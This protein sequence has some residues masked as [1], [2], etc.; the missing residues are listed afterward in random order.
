MSRC[1]GLVAP[2]AALAVAVAPA[3]GQSLPSCEH[4][5]YR[6]NFRLNGAEQH[7]TLAE[8]GKTEPHAEVAHALQLLD[9]ARRAGGVDQATLWYLFAR[10]YVLNHD[11]VGA[12]SA[13]TKAEGATDA[14]C[15]AQIG[16]LRYNQW[17]PLFNS[18]LEQMN[19]GHT[20]S[21]LAMFRQANGIYRSRPDAYVFMA[22]LFEQENPPQDDSA[23]RYFR[24]AAASTTEPKYT[25]AREEA[26][27]N[28]ARLVQ[29][30]ASDSAGVHAE[31]QQ[32]GVSDSAVKDARLHL[33]ETAY[34]DVLKLRPRDMAAL[35][36]L[37]GVMT[38]LHETD[39]AKMVYD[40]M[41]AHAD[42]ADPTS[43]FDA[44][45]PLIRSSQYAL[46][47]QFIE[48]GLTR[49]QCDRDALFNL[50]NAYMG[51]KDT[52]HMLGAARRLLAV[53]SMNR[54][55]LQ[56]LARAFQDTGNRDSTLRALLRADSLPWEI[57]TLKFDLGDSTA[58][59]HGMVTNLR[60]APMKGFTLNVDFV[61]GAC[62]VV[63]SQTVEI[64]DLSA[65]GSPG[66]AYDF[67]LTPNGRG[68]LAWKYRTN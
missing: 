50:A 46:A 54:S 66:Q 25:D 35:A 56:L 26:L 2:L 38:A 64:P 17:V 47:A 31:A 4:L 6:N 18:G 7:L 22:N 58:T 52:T 43:L 60:T 24:L 63:S 10:A 34:Q 36:S 16:R 49:D 57:S 65:N 32:R 42:S 23:I 62:A 33:A 9:Q 30:A 29:R 68:I 39:Q 41:L 51:A 27:F 14:N 44:A 59:L 21:A 12:D 5:N 45:V 13:W 28:V 61:N 15:R 19:A 48:K 1:L 53:D 11:M 3:M 37:A 40:T 20:D 55:S 8:G 67:T